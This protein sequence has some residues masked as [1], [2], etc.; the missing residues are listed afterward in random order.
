MSELAPYYGSVVI[1]VVLKN[2]GLRRD[3][4]RF[5]ENYYAY[6][7]NFPLP[8]EVRVCRSVYV[9]LEAN[10]LKECSIPA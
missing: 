3:V 6:Y 7:A 4:R 9:A 8:S 5:S 2:A 1:S 10:F